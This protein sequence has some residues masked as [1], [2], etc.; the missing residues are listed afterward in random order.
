MMNFFEFTTFL[1][2]RKSINI[3]YL[4]FE[5]PNLKSIRSEL[6]IP[7]Q[8]P[9]IFDNLTE[10]K[11]ILNLTP[12]NQFKSLNSF[13]TKRDIILAIVHVQYKKRREKVMIIKI[14]GC[15]EITVISNSVIGDDGNS[16]KL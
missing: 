11:K 15:Q 12:Q 8:N 5:Y 10:V 13:D 7:E 6:K 4:L 16:F 9:T 1:K 3:S 2:Y 14:V